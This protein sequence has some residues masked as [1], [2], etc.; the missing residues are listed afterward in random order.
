M[1][2]EVSKTLT[3]FIKY[4][5]LKHCIHLI[6]SLTKTRAMVRNEKVLSTS[7]ICFQDGT[8]WCLLK[9]EETL[10]HPVVEVPGYVVKHCPKSTDLDTACAEKL[11]RFVSESG[12]QKRCLWR[13]RGDSHHQTSWGRGSQ[14]TRYLLTAEARIGKTKKKT[15]ARSKKQRKPT[16]ITNTCKT[17]K[18]SNRNK[19]P[20]LTEYYNHT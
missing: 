19:Y 20:Q 8:P 6:R 17:C 15:T 7:H 13:D 16:K 10:E 14:N 4:K 9:S 5:P 18:Y 11:Q 1:D 3:I 12:V 2:E